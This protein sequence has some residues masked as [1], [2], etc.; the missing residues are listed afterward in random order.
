MAG[1]QFKFR[2][3]MNFKAIHM[4]KEII[5]SEKKSLDGIYWGKMQV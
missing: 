1:D 4:L 3:L 5:L 2:W